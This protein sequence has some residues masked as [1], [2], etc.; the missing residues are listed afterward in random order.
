MKFVVC[1]LIVDFTCCR[2]CNESIPSRCCS[3]CYHCRWRSSSYRSS[4]NL[5]KKKRGQTRIPNEHERIIHASKRIVFPHWW[6][7][8]RRLT[9]V[10]GTLVGVGSTRSVVMVS[11]AV[12]AAVSR[13][14][15]HD[16]DDE[17]CKKSSNAKKW[18]EGEEEE[19]IA[20]KEYEPLRRNK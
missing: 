6:R 10:R 13:S 17:V 1:S 12:V 11:L 2:S 16:G 8:T 7:R 4:W 15:R 5:T 18:H 19:Q 9:M 14:T 3:K 20:S